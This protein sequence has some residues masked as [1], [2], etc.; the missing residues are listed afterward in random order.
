MNKENLA[1]R[2]NQHL[3]KIYSESYHS[4]EITVLTNNIVN[5]Y[6]GHSSKA[7]YGL[8]LPH[9]SVFSMMIFFGIIGVFIFLV[10][11]SF[12][13]ITNKHNSYYLILVFYFLTNLLKS[14]S[15]LYL[16]SFLLFL[17][18]LNTNHMFEANE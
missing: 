5:Y 2:L 15:L 16:N 17:F 3:I 14:D 1:K 7:N 11:C 4:E 13:L 9:S 18:I 6:L 10:W 8:I 12:K